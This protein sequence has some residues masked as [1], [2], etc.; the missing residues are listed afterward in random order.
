MANETNM[1]TTSVEKVEINLDEIFSGAPGASSITL[2]EDE[3]KKPNVFSRGEEVDL[4][5]LDEKEVETESPKEETPEDENKKV[6][7]EESADNTIQQ[8]TK[9]KE[10]TVSADE[11]DEI[12]NE[13]LELA[14]KEESKSTAKGRRRIE[15][16]SDV[17]TQMIDKGK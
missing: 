7:P 9:P 12:L 13:G 8:E 15:G 4:S 14:E 17:F 3:V 5:F 11:V 16:M 1:E 10:S 6:E 2:P